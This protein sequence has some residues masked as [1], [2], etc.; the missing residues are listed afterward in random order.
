MDKDMQINVQANDGG[1]VKVLT[2][3]NF[4]QL[5]DVTDATFVTE[6]LGSFVSFV[7]PLVGNGSKVFFTTNSAICIDDEIGFDTEP[8]AKVSLTKSNILNTLT[9]NNNKSFG[10]SEI[11]ELLT[12]MRPYYSD[13]ALQL[14]TVVRNTKVKAIIEAERSIDNKGNYVFNVSRKGGGNDQLDIPEVVWFEV[15]MFELIPTTIKIPFEVSFNYRETGEAAR[16]LDI[17]WLLRCVNIN[18]L[19]K[20]SSIEMMLS[21]FADLDQD[22]V[23]SGSLTINKKTDSWK[24]Q[25]SSGRVL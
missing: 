10:P 17:T 19:I 3:K 1:E 9:A 25:E 11:D 5:A 4:Y 7:K 18:E 20:E 13:Y 2:G 14:L 8:Q 16:P 21:Y 12:I 6:S 15:P 24:I 22:S 23:F